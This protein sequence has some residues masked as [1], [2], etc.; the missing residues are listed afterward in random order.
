MISD[1]RILQTMR[2]ALWCGAKGKLS[3]LL[4]TYWGGDEKFDLMA[5][6]IKEFGKQVDDNGWAE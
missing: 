2:A 1:E 4:C 5:K 3:A 6:A